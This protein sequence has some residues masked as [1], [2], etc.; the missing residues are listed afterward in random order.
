M[1][2]ECTNLSITTT[3]GYYIG[4]LIYLI[5]SK[6]CR[7]EPLLEAASMEMCV[8]GW[9][10]IKSKFTIYNNIFFHFSLFLALSVV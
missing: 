10:G 1:H 9:S 6:Q 2:L 8:C 3:S 5:L 4:A 7:K